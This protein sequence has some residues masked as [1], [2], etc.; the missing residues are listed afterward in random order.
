[1]DINYIH[2]LIRLYFDGESTLEQERE[3]RSLLGAIM[4]PPTPEIEEAMAVMGYTSVMPSPGMAKV[5]KRYAWKPAVAAAASVLVAVAIGWMVVGQG[6]DYENSCV[7]Y[8]G[9]VQ[10]V[11]TEQ[12]MGLMDSQLSSISSA[13]NDINVEL[14]EQKEAF[15]EILNQL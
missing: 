5:K 10:V 9:G 8:V 14:Q 6:H 3:L 4:Q 2:R 13:Q 7:A 15:S 11:S 12:V 1:M